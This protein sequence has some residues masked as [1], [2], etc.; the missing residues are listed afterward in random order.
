M[1]LNQK[2]KSYV[3]NTDMSIVQIC[4]YCVQIAELM[5]TGTGLLSKLWS[6]TVQVIIQNV[7]GVIIWQLDGILFV[8]IYWSLNR[9]EIGPNL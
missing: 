6:L 2:R 3:Q 5:Y 4:F 1:F 7:N 8:K 9:P